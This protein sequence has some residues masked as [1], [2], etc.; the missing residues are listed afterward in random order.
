VILA[1][2]LFAAQVFVPPVP[3][4][5]AHDGR[6][7]NQTAIALPAE[8]EKWVRVQSPHFTVIS[9]AGENETRE[10]VSNLE[11]LAIVLQQ[12]HPRFREAPLAH[13]RVLLFE[14]RNEAQPYF[15]LL[16]SRGTRSPGAFVSG[17][18]GGTMVLFGRRRPDR[19]PYHELVHNLLNGPTRPPLWLE[20]G[21]AEYYS[22]ADFF[23]SKI[24]LGLPYRPAYSGPMRGMRP[25]TELFAVPRD[26]EMTG[27]TG[28]YRQASGTIGWLLRTDR[29]A[30]DAFEHDVEHGVPVE[31][32]LRTH[33]HATPADLQQGLAGMYYDRKRIVP[34]PKVDVAITSQ[35]LSRADILYELGSFLN[36]FETTHADAVRHFE[37]AL[38]ADPHHARA[39]A[40]LRH[41]DDA[42][43]A[44]PDDPEILLLYAESLLG[45]AIG[46]FAGTGEVTDVASYRKARD[47][48]QHALEHGADEARARG[49]LG[50]SFMAE[51]DV[52]PAIAPLE[53]AHQLAPR[54]RDFALHLYD[55]YVRTG[56][57]ADALYA[58]LAGSG[59]KQV[60][61]A[62]K[63]ILLRDLTA[64]ANALVD[65][66]QL[67]EAAAIVRQLA[68]NTA[69]AAARRDLE[70][71]AAKLEKT[72]E[73]NRHIVE[74]NKALEELK[75]GDR[76][77]ALKR[78]DALLAVASDE[79]VIADAKELRQE[80]LRR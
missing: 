29:N 25:M 13:S 50:V 71:Q 34:R 59:D 24:A 70:S 57:N 14:R 4:G 7:L 36:E 18:E 11:T 49:D 33:Y 20:E 27:D 79:Q 51:Q 64:R 35:Q 21:L 77:A 69:D 61:F 58:E 12:L 46:P 5:I 37:A 67:D 39:M 32:A 28:F 9:S 66:Q 41:F 3:K 62:A 76:K 38:Q 74:Y 47:L 17:D 15:D 68:A 8:R 65:R 2:L 60:I 56:R 6:A 78:I 16:L 23:P 73:T 45:R 43:A 31:A 75:Q 48:A 54:R 53:R 22:N 52:T 30:F 42:I 19:T 44:A 26:A 10:L 72:A 63:T 55:A 1:P 80:L 40:G